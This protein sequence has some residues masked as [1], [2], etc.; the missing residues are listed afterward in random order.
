MD[1]SSRFIHS[2]QNLEATKM[3]FSRYMDKSALVDPDNEILFKY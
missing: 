3:S 2:C 1:I